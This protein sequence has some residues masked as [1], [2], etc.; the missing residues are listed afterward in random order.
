MA[1]LLVALATIVIVLMLFALF[2]APATPEG[3]ILHEAGQEMRDAMS[4]LFGNRPDVDNERIVPIV[5]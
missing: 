4:R 1:N 3:S 5:D 2:V